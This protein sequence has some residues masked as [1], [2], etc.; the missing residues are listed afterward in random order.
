MQRNPTHR[1]R[2]FSEFLVVPPAAALVSLCMIV[3]EYCLL[4]VAVAI[5][6]VVA[7]A[8]VRSFKRAASGAAC[9][10]VP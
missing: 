2:G 1:R 8:L 4:G 10:E 3:P 7:A 5:P 6:S 9:R